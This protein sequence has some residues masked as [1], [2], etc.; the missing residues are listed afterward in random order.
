M[1]RR[2]RGK[3]FD[4]GVTDLS[5]T[6]MPRKF[7]A[8]S[9][10]IRRRRGLSHMLTHG[11]PLEIMTPSILT[12]VTRCDSRNCRRRYTTW[13]LHILSVNTMSTDLERLRVRL[14]ARQH[15]SILSGSAALVI[16]TFAAG[17]MT[18]ISSAYLHSEFPWVAATILAAVTTYDAGLI[19]ELYQPRLR[20]ISGVRP[21]D[22]VQCEWPWNKSISTDRRCLRCPLSSGAYLCVLYIYLI[23]AK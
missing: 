4:G 10:D 5:T 20:A 9:H 16:S 17:M 14:F 8:V 3:K 11:Q 23:V 22:S 18:Y 21:T 12:D 2:R 6:S 19:L 13:H 7:D 15:S 1:R